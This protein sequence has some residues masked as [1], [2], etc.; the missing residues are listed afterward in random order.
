MLPVAAF[1]VVDCAWLLPRRFP[2]TLF[3]GWEGAG[4]RCVCWPGQTT[5]LEA[6]FE[7]V[8]VKSLVL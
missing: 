2:G 6:S 1:R 5:L 3:N 8:K 7:Y 4:G